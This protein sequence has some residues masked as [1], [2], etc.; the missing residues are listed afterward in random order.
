MAER[1]RRG[2]P[3]AL[4]DFA[5]A[6]SAAVV[7][8]MLG[9]LLLVSVVLP[10]DP[11]STLPRS[12]SDRYVS[13][14]HVA[15]LKTF[16]AAIV[17]RSAQS[18]T[19]RDAEALLTALPQCR[20]AWGALGIDERV[21]QAVQGGAPPPTFADRIVAEM[22]TLDAALRR[23]SARPNARVERPVGFD[24]P[25]W[26]VAAQ[27]A[28][29][30]PIEVP[31]SPG[32]R[33][34][35]RCADL[36][37][38]LG[39]L[40]RAD[41]RMLDSLA[42]RGT[43]NSSVLAHWQPHQQMAVDA[44]DVTRRN[45]WRGL[46]GCIYLGRTESG[47]AYFV[48]APRS[49]R[50]RLCALPAMSAA[51]SGFAP[52]ALAGEPRP[53]DAID[54]PRWSVPPSLATLLQPLEPLRQPSATAEGT[55]AGV[56]D[57]TRLAVPASLRQR[58]N[59]V[60]V[61][62]VA[63]QAG[64]SVDITIDPALQALAQ[65]AVACY[66]GRQDVCRALGIRRQEE[67]DG[68]VGQ[69]LLEGAMVRMA[70]VAIIDV[71]SGRI[72]ALAGALS[73]C[74]RQEFDGPG[75]AAACDRRLPYPVRYRPD[76]LLNPAVFHDA[77]PA[78]TIKPIMAAAFLSD[79]EVGARWLAARA[80]RHGA[81]CSADRR[82]PARPADALGLGALPRSHVLPRQG[83]RPLPPPVGRPGGRVPVRLEPRLC[84]KAERI[85]AS[86]TCCS[87]AASRAPRRTASHRRH[88]RWPTGG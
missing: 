16:E 88:C 44:R 36:A 4:L 75:R 1:Q 60:V 10:I 11:A 37:E 8:V 46:A 29:D 83:L 73:P 63:V 76:A 38:A 41:A 27:R 58:V 17:V 84:A 6:A 64:L 55:V 87:A 71:A 13:V 40:T 62:G 43:E 21:L 22:A 68:S 5:I 80:H 3:L 20:R 42:W 57:A 39:A 54:D 86:T 23:F 9:M 59:E 33:F 78:S 15:A 31:E 35:L 70:A 26:F 25:R 7:P 50:D 45:P 56:V 61:D 34:R 12:N 77:M 53:L 19:P 65:K 49:A 66:T 14:R 67:K 52:R 47:P 82:Q 85:A 32:Q 81:K 28:L 2:R 51:A 30:E 79:P 24:A 48:G 69:A 74:A 72:E 18:R